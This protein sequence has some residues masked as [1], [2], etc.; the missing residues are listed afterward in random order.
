MNHK[1]IVGIDEAGRGPLAGPVVAAAV[2]MPITIEEVKDSKKLSAIKREKLFE[3]IIKLSKYGIGIASVEEVD[4]INILQ[5]TMLAMK[6][7]YEQ[8]NLVADLVL[9]DGNKAPK[10]NCIDFQTIIKGDD[11]VPIISTASILAKVT[12]D[13]LMNELAKEYPQYLWSKN[14]G[15][16]TKEHLEAIKKYGITK[17]HRLTFAPI[18][19]CLT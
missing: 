18:K 4:E 5:A 19:N 1:I 10:L 9:I 15:Y 6:R 12:R 16:G 14:S 17:H 3:Q 7:S 8:L 13:R 11:L 2:I